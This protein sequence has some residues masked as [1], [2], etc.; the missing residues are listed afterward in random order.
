M[1]EL[2]PVHHRRVSYFKVA[3]SCDSRDT[4][5]GDSGYC[6]HRRITEVSMVI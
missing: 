3:K 6:V 4:C 2:L 1:R 5:P